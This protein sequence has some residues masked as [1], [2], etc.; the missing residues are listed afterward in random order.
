MHFHIS[1]FTSLVWNHNLCLLYFENYLAFCLHTDITLMILRVLQLEETEQ[2]KAALRAAELELQTRVSCR[3]SYL[4]YSL[5]YRLLWKYLQSLYYQ[6]KFNWFYGMAGFNQG[7]VLQ[8][9]TLHVD[10]YDS[11]LAFIHSNFS[12]TLANT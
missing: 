5:Q 10:L 12:S 9:Y 11:V 2:L 6:L 7:F 8:L 4:S 3:H 1:I